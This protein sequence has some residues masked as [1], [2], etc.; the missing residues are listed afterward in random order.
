MPTFARAQVGTNQLLSR[1][2]PRERREILAKCAEVLLPFGEVLCEPEA[3]IR[4][5]YFPIE[6][7][8][9]LITPP[10][11]ANSLEIALVGNEGIFGGTVVLGVNT[12]P[13][14]GLV[15]GAGSGLRMGVREF[16]LA[17]AKHASLKQ[18]VNAY[19]Y[20]QFAQIAQI[21]ACGRFHDLHARL[22]RWLLMTQD[23]AASDTFK[24]THTFLAQMLGVR[25]AGVTTAAGEMQRRK[26]IHY[27]RG[28]VQVLNRPALEAAAC[29]CYQALNTLYSEKLDVTR[30]R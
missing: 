20:V 7:F 6:G 16:R 28:V 2:A 23:R 13:L 26:Y 4:H 22:A 12:S 14:R 11:A 15:Q 3:Q 9:S 29:R 25:R 1:V 19:L 18:V 10:G 30:K 21:A 8:V 24:L 27:R 17:Y 5:V